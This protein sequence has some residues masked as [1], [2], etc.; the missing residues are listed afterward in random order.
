MALDGQTFI[1]L[2]LA[3]LAR[4]WLQALFGTQLNA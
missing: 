2:L 1:T 3:R 4:T